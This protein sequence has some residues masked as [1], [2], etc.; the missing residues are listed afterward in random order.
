[1]S[2]HLYKRQ[3]YLDTV[4]CFNPVSNTWQSINPMIAPLKR[5]CS[6]VTFGGT[7]CYVIGQTLTTSFSENWQTDNLILPDQHSSYSCFDVSTNS[8]DIPSSPLGCQWVNFPMIAAFGGS[9]LGHT[10]RS[11]VLD[12]NDMIE[13][14]NPETDENSSG[15]SSF[16]TLDS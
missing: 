8:W 14:T 7:H 10:V 13:L 1:M 15:S 12:P 3:S 16:Y 11:M 9:I 2:E 4:E 6:V 5:G